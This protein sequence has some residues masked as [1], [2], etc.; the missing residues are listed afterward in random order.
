MHPV[1]MVDWNLALAFCTKLSETTGKCYKLPSES[2]WEYACRAGT[3]TPFF[4]GNSSQYIWKYGYLEVLDL[5]FHFDREGYYEH[6]IRSRE[7]A[8]KHASAHVAII[9]GRVPAYPPYCYNYTTNT[10]QLKPNPW[11]LHDLLGNVWEWCEDD[12]I[13]GYYGHPIDGSARI[14]GGDVKVVRG[15]CFQGSQ[16][17]CYS[18]SRGYK[19]IDTAHETVGFRI[20]CVS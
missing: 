13:D 11:G 14:N 9:H 19:R 2:Q 18:F 12:W 16:L 20:A 4:F 10:G 8:N 17:D 6:S 1:Q 7:S 3:Q 15:G 5:L